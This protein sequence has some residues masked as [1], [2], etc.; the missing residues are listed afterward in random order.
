VV[1]QVR[2]LRSHPASWLLTAGVL[3]AG[4]GSWEAPVEEGTPA[5]QGEALLWND[6]PSKIW[7]LPGTNDVAVCFRSNAWNNWAAAIRKGVQDAMEESWGTFT[8]LR[9]TGFG[10]CPANQ[11]STLVVDQM[12]SGGGLTWWDGAAGTV[13]TSYNIP[14]QC[15]PGGPSSCQDTPSENDI[16]TFIHETGHALGFAHEQERSDNFDA[17]DNPIYCNLHERTVMS[18]GTFL[19]DYYDGYSMMNYCTFDTVDWASNFSWKT[20]TNGLSFGD[21]RGSQEEFGKSAVGEW[22][23]AQFAIN[24]VLW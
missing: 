9:F 2:L 12:F 10:L 11:T 13:V 19:T 6:D 18:N 8:K 17:L 15:V 7:P 20:N 22:A 24:N 16:N 3:V 4:C 23:D 14:G 21:I 1:D 5:E